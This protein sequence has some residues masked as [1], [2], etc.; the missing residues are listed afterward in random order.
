MTADTRC[1]GRFRALAMCWALALLLCGLGEPAQA[2]TLTGEEAHRRTA[3]ERRLIQQQLLPVLFRQEEPLAGEASGHL[4]AHRY[5]RMPVD[6]FELRVAG[7]FEA[8]YERGAMPNPC[9]LSGRVT[10]RAP[11]LF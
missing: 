7:Y 3:L 4:L 10:G 1:Y 2:A 5:E 8:L 9:V 6:C 11:P